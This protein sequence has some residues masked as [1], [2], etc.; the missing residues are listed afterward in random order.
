MTIGGLD[1]RPTPAP[2]TDV[3][4]G[5]TAVVMVPGLTEGNH[6]VKVTA[7]SVTG[8]LS[9]KVVATL[10]EVIAVSTATE[11]VFA[12]TIAADNLVR[13]WKFSNADQ[14]WS[15]YDPR[16]AFASANTLSDTASGD[17]VW[18][19]VTAEESFQSGTLYPGWNLIALD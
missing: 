13:V 16:D 8:S 2:S 10:A 11:D 5:F 9:L 18:V 1:V 14:S 4:G 6:T 17:I 15:F 3:D 19:N 7:S 12:D